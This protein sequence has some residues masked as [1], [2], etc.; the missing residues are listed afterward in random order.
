MVSLLLLFDNG[1]WNFPSGDGNRSLL[2]RRLLLLLG[3]LFLFSRFRLLDLFLDH[4]F[5]CAFR[6]GIVVAGGDGTFRQFLLLLSD[7]FGGGAGLIHLFGGSGA[8]SSG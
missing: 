3:L 8:G 5:A 2:A 6:R 4:G 7:Y 1:R